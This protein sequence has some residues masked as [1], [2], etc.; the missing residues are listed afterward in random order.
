MCGA[1]HSHIL[2]SQIFIPYVMFHYEY[3]RLG[4]EVKLIS[5]L[6]LEE[7]GGMSVQ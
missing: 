5:V 1:D 3:F 6:L 2:Q 4:A 7:L